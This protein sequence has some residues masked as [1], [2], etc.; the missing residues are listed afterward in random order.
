MAAEPQCEV[1]FS[2]SDFLV[3]QLEGKARLSQ[4]RKKVAETSDVPAPAET[5]DP[6]EESRGL[7][8][9]PYVVRLLLLVPF[10]LLV[11]FLLASR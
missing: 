10:V 5:P 7:D 11:W 9:R 8:W 3:S 2:D 6:P 1:D 4:V